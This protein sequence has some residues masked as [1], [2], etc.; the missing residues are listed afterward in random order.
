M[1]R[2]NII[3]VNQPLE[4]PRCPVDSFKW[5]WHRQSRETLPNFKSGRTRGF[6][7][8]SSFSRL[9]HNL[10]FFH[11]LSANHLN[12]SHD[13]ASHRHHQL[14]IRCCQRR[15]DFGLYPPTRGRVEMRKRREISVSF[16]LGLLRFCAPHWCL[17]WPSGHSRPTN[18]LGFLWQPFCLLPSGCN[19]DLEIWPPSWALAAAS[20]LAI[21]VRS[22]TSQG[23]SAEPRGVRKLSC[24]HA[25]EFA[26]HL[27]KPDIGTLVL[28]RLEDSQR[29]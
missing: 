17:V 3:A 11:D 23:C 14:G 2:P 16:D 7:H 24:D 13:H 9:F 20:H 12:T 21:R 1:K 8:I 28:V 25:F 5:D 4:K 18:G 22:H 29:G 15:S 27:V 6:L 26:R 10:K 19:R